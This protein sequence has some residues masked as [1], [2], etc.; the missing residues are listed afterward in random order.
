MEHSVAVQK[1]KFEPL[2]DGRVNF[3]IVRKSDGYFSIGDK[4]VIKG[5]KQGIYIGKSVKREITFVQGQ[6]EVGPY[7]KYVALSL[8]PFEVTEKEATQEMSALEY[9]TH[10]ARMTK[11]CNGIGQ[12]ECKYCSFS[13]YMNKRHVSCHELEQ[14]DPKK[15][16]DQVKNWAKEHPVATY[17]SVLREKLPDIP[18]NMRGIPE[19]CIKNYFG[20]ASEEDCT[21]FKNC[22]ECWNRPYKLEEK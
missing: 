2:A 7:I 18:V 4:I 12:H 15:F 8:R 14:L 1:E 19:T 9:L 22:I 5:H 13:V 3:I 11:S 21:K 10:K 16:I 20:K 17:I 6:E